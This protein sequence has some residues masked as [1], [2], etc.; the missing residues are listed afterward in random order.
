MFRQPADGAFQTTV[1]AGSLNEL[2][3]ALKRRTWPTVMVSC[4]V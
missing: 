1:N 2:V 4:V 3:A